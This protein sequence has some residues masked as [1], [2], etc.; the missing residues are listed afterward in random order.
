MLI[1]ARK[2][3]MDDL[4]KFKD[5]ALMRNLCTDYTNRWNS[6]QDEDD[7]VRMAIDANGISY[8]CHSIAN[9]WGLNVE[10]LSNRF[11]NYINGNKVY[12][13]INKKG[14]GYSSELL[15]CYGG[16]SGERFEVRSTQICVINS[17][18]VLSIPACAY[19]EVHAVNSKIE[20]VTGTRALVEV[21]V[22]GDNCHIIG[23]SNYK[24]RR[25][26]DDE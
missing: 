4:L 23:N 14:N 11:K 22:Y 21:V 17:K 9:G 7:L 24:L 6:A 19:V 16:I 2:T 20:V 12:K 5:N 1:F 26:K 13:Y 18:V 25:C 8:M 10:Y 3:V 15:C